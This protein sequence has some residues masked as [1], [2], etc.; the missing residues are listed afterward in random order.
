MASCFVSTEAA[1]TDWGPSG[2]L[3]NELDGLPTLRRD[4]QFPLVAV[5]EHFTD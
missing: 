3:C 4:Q 5:E 1:N 2:D